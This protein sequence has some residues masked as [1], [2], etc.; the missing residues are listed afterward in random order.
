MAFAAKRWLKRAIAE[1]CGAAANLRLWLVGA[2]PEALRPPI[3]DR[4]RTAQF[5][6]ATQRSTAMAFANIGNGLVIVALAINGPQMGAALIWF[7]V[8]LA[9]WSPYALKWWRRRGKAAPS[10]IRELTVRRLVRHAFGLG[11]L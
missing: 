4:L 5:A 11:L 3:A 2:E 6:A 8:L 10:V 7:A 9:Y 1:P